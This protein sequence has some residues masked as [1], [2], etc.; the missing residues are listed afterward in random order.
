[1]FNI[2][3]H[4]LNAI[5]ASVLLSLTIGSTS[6][7]IIMRRMS[8]P[9]MVLLHSVLAGGALGVVITSYFKVYALELEYAITLSFV[10]AL[11]ILI[12]FLVRKGISVDIATSIVVAL[13]SSLSVIFIGLAAMI[14]YEGLARIWGY[15]LGEFYLLTIDDIMMLSLVTIITLTIA[16]LFGAKIIV[17]SFDEE[18][19][20]AHGLNVA[21]Y[22]YLLYVI[23]SLVVVVA[24]R[25][26]GVIVVHIVL[27]VPGALAIRYPS[28]LL[29]M[30]F[31]G[32]TISLLS[33]FG[34]IFLSIIFNL[35]PSG[36]TGL[37][38]FLAYIVEFIKTRVRSS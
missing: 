10:L 25:V 23:T 11:T 12:A 24:V 3:I 4:I 2:P 14:S 17:M 36:F 20:E 1:M 38:L 29:L 22:H 21:F 33:L 18:G 31:I 7:F 26:V 16:V 28:N 27:L 19:A 8:F 6:P 35:Q 34:G 15:L 5:I 9:V 37:L 32:F 13:T 30:I